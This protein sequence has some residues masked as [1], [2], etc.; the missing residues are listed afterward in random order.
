MLLWLLKIASSGFYYITPQRE[1]TFVLCFCVFLK[2]PITMLYDDEQREAATR[3]IP[4]SYIL[5]GSV[6]AQHGLVDW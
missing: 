1:I 6:F 5:S 4:L 3:E 2:H